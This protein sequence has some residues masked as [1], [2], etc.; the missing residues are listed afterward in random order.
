LTPY[1][2]RRYLDYGVFDALRQMKRLIEQEVARK[3][4]ADHVKLGPGGIREIEFI[5]QAYQLVRGG[6]DPRLRTPSLLEALPCLAT[7]REL[8]SDGVARLGAA[9]RYLRTVENRIQAMDDRQ[10]H[11]LPVDAEA[12]ARLAYAHGDADWAAFTGRLAAHR[13]A[14]ERE[15]ERIAWDGRASGGATGDGGDAAV[16]AWEAGDIGAVL[17]DT[18]LDGNED[19]AR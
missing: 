10:T 2:Y 14:V 4:M 7:E 9:Y 19:V 18:P 16:E 13:G 15:F 8:G 1:V 6:R 17:A 11:V 5:V 3:E 12:R